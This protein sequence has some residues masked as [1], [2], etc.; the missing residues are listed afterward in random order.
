LP[1]VSQRS[2]GRQDGEE[3]E[4]AGE[5][6]QIGG[7]Q[8]SE[9]WLHEAE[10]G[11]APRYISNATSFKACNLV[12]WQRRVFGTKRDEV[13]GG[14]RKLH[15]E[16]LHNFYCPLSIIRM[17]RSKR[18]RWARHVARMGGRGMRIGFWWESQTERDH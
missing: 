5:E 10:E 4:E 16:E 12:I 18:L 9:G 17:I 3:Q 13:I 7:R 11:G 1:S 2:R 8:S 6:E 14:W 15:N